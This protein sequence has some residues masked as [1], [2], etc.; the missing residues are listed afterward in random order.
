MPRGRGN[1]KL[2][3]SLLLV[4]FLFGFGLDTISE[5]TDKE[6]SP[7]AS[8]MLLWYREDLK[9]NVEL[10]S[11]FAL[12]EMIVTPDGE[13]TLAGVWGTPWLA[14]IREGLV[15]WEI[16]TPDQITAASSAFDGGVI[17]GSY[18]RVRHF[19][20]IDPG[21]DFDVSKYD[22]RGKRLWEKTFGTS[23]HELVMAIAPL[24]NGGAAVTGFS[25]GD[26]HQLIR[27]NS[28]G[29]I[30]WYRAFG[31]TAVDSAVLELG[32]G[33]LFAI[34]QDK[35]MGRLACWLFDASG[36][37]LDA[38]GFRS[39][40][41]AEAKSQCC[42]TIHLRQDSGDTGALYVASQYNDSGEVG[43][44]ELAR[45]SPDG[46][47]IWRAMM[48]SPDGA[49]IFWINAQ[50]GIEHAPTKKTGGW[51]HYALATLPNGDALIVFAAY[52][53][54][55]LY[56]FRASDGSVT[57]Q[58]IPLGACSLLY[59]GLHLSVPDDHS[60]ILGAAGFVDNFKRDGIKDRK[61]SL[62]D[63]RGNSC[64]WIARIA[65]NAVH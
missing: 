65:L 16:K 31:G 9:P 23:R 21:S 30:E 14:R 2:L 11:Y 51:H 10:A 32:N 62:Q 28:S 42:W 20:D 58:S 48:Q 38:C 4:T 3:P 19:L 17:V 64:V 29:I 13:I 7:D 36:K 24:R 52:G 44:I 25:S 8:L 45:I 33:S 22:K 63:G 55:S 41:A 60:V 40:T 56:R 35:S 46:K 1:M 53:D 18:K 12:K 37:P 15:L 59:R 61:A 54:L 43:P 27:F 6:T 26:S 50:N 34:S 57:K 39:I 5:E 49:T 47:L